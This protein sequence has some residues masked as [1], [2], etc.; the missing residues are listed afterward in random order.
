MI[1]WSGRRDSNPRPQ[2][3][4]GCALPLSYA[5]SELTP[6][7]RMHVSAEVRRAPSMLLGAA[8]RLACVSLWPP[9]RLSIWA[10]TAGCEREH[11]KSGDPGSQRYRT[12]V[13]RALRAGGDPALDDGA[14]DPRLL[15]R[16][17]RTVQAA[18]ADPRQGRG[19]LCRQG[20]QARQDRRRQGQIARGAV[21]H[22]VDP[23]RLRNLPR[24]AGRGPHQPP[25]RR[26]AQKGA[27]PAARAAQDRARGR[28][29]TGRDRA[30]RGDGRAG[31]R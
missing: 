8:A 29:A 14:G 20:C 7:T 4:Q 2:P 15:G 13:D 3:W 9:R 26:P 16:M 1:I 22:P 25:Q 23:D 11:Q 6:A 17:V 18:L 19:R 28:N 5:R 27:R 10:R 12:R 31:S 30:A 24:P 21:P